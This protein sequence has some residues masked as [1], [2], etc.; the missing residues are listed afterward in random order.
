MPQTGDLACNPGTCPDWE[1]NWQ[2]FRLQASAESRVPHQPGLI[3]IYLNLLRLIFCPHLLSIL[4]NVSWVVEKNVYSAALTWNALKTSIKS[5][6]FNVSFKAPASVSIFCLMIYPLV[7]WGVKILCNY[8]ISVDLSFY[9]HQGLLYIFRCSFVGCVNVY[10]GFILFLD[11][12]PYHYVVSFFFLVLD[13]VLKSILSD[14]NIATQLS[15][16]S[17][18]IKYQYL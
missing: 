13:F 11:W 7:R 16:V 10:K 2:S 6:W 18:C 12:L 5:I 3:S 17:I 9:V 8:C 14:I 1:L 15:F 4:E